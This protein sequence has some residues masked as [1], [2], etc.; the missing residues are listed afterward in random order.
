MSG[1]AQAVLGYVYPTLVTPDSSTIHVLTVGN[2][3]SLY[4]KTMNIT[5]GGNSSTDWQSLGGTIT[6]GIVAA[7]SRGP[8]TLNAFSRGTNGD[9]YH[10][11]L[12][13]ST[14]GPSTYDWDDR[15]GQLQNAPEVISWGDNRLD[16]FAIGEGNGLN[17]MSWNT[18]NQA[19]WGSWIPLGG[20]FSTKIMPSAVSWGKGR[21]D[22]F[23]VGKRDGILYRRFLDKNATNWQP[24]YGFENLGGKLTG[25]PIV[26]TWGPGRLDVFARGGDGGLWHMFMKEGLWSDWHWLGADIRGE[27]AAVSCAKDRIDVFVWGEDFHYYS[28]GFDGTN[29]SPA[30]GF[31]PMGGGEFGGPPKV[32]TRS[33][34]VIDLFGYS[35]RGSVM[36]RSWDK[37]TFGWTPE[38]GF[39][40]WGGP[41]IPTN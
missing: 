4:V 5:S 26:V 16:V 12:S 17:T 19:D 10:K 40:N 22:V 29:W 36:H 39:E 11:Y 23:A 1:S 14:W 34:G 3:A 20:S 31:K 33:E 28:K 30:E 21:I 6:P 25:R 7:V 15:K 13:N 18:S 38:D 2:N 24:F 8:G 32:I 35:S 41:G 9:L 27:P 37:K